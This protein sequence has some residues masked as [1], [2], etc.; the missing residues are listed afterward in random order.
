MYL[1]GKK[2]NNKPPP[3]KKNLKTRSFKQSEYKN[4]FYS[5]LIIKTNMYLKK[6]Y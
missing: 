1:G 5:I 3:T 4:V 2:K 6:M